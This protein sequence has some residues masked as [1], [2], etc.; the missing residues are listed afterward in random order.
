MR[1]T[2]RKQKQDGM[3]I[4]YKKFFY[5]KELRIPKIRLLID[6]LHFIS[7]GYSR[8]K[9]I[10]TSRYGKLSELAAAHICCITSLPVILNCNPNWIQEFYG[11]LTISV[12]VLETMKKLKDIKGYVRLTL[13]KLPGI[14]VDLLRLDEN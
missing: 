9:S 1:V 11:K 14:R 4:L 6:G 8:T 10:L 7:E 12:Q 3:K 13:D 5:S 2:E